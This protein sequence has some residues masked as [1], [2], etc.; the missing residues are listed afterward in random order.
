MAKPANKKA[1]MAIAAL[2]IIAAVAFFV[3]G[4]SG[5]GLFI[6]ELSFGSGTEQF[7]GTFEAANKLPDT[8]A[9]D[10]ANPYGYKNPFSGG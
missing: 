9:F 1:I 3:L 10:E 2:V 4:G 5:G 8:N 6:P 7:E